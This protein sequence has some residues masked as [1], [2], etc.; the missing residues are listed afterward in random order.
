[1]IWKSFL[2]K[3][4]VQQSWRILLPKRTQV[5]DICPYVT[6]NINI[7]YCLSLYKRLALNWA[8]IPEFPEACNDEAGISL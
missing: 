2:G 3:S 6:K 8:F 1:M 7:R 5:I 4:I